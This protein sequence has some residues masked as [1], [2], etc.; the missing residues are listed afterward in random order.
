MYNA[1]YSQKTGLVFERQAQTVINVDS[2]FN[3]AY[4][5]PFFTMSPLSRAK[6]VSLPWASFMALLLAHEHLAFYDGSF[7]LNSANRVFEF[8]GQIPHDMFY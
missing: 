4:P 5:S 7:T 1:S 2:A 3:Y 8:P 6:P